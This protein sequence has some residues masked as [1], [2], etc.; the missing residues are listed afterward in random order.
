M[1]ALADSCLRCARQTEV[2]T[3]PELAKLL[4]AQGGFEACAS[5]PLLHFR[6]AYRRR[7]DITAFLPSQRPREPRRPPSPPTLP[8]LRSPRSTPPLLPSPRLA[9]ALPSL[10]AAS[11]SAY[12]SCIAQHER[13]EA[14]TSLSDPFFPPSYSS[15]PARPLP[16]RWAAAK[17]QAPSDPDAY[18]PLIL[19]NGEKAAQTA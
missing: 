17:E 18:F 15:P 14:L 2:V 8:L 5:L 10:P 7:L 6:A 9:S 12:E 11:T 19:F 3:Q 13:A 4:I 1:R 16:R